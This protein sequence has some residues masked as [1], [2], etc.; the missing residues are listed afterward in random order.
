MR[1]QE[2]QA[3]ENQTSTT[4]ADRRLHQS[5]WPQFL[6]EE[7]ERLDA[8]GVRAGVI[9]VTLGNPDDD[10]ELH[11][12][13]RDRS[14]RL[15]IHIV[16]PSGRLAPT[17]ERSVAVL[18]APLGSLPELERHAH[19]VAT[20]LSVAGIPAAV[21]FAHRRVD[22]HLLDTWARADAEADR[23]AFRIHHPQGGLHLR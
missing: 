13:Y 5:S 7:S 18:E 4:P 19:A 15:L 2:N 12:T 21:G 14:L 3:S 11:R 22:E 23:A 8:L 1:S 9:S 6:D 16:A 17:S 20:S 10:A